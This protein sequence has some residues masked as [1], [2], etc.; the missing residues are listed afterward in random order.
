MG[1]KSSSPFPSFEAA[2]NLLNAMEIDHLEKSFKIISK[3]SDT[4]SLA[5]FTEV[6]LNYY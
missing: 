6:L 3:G 1:N 5:N 4:I 2:R